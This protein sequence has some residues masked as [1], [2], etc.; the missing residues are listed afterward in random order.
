MRDRIAQWYTDTRKDLFIGACIAFIVFITVGLFRL[1]APHVGKAPIIIEALPH[2]ATVQRAG[3]REGSA[4]AERLGAFV[5][6]RNGKKYY[7]PDCP[8]ANRIKP[9]NR[10]WFASVREA[11]ETGYEPAANCPA[12]QP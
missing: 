1:A 2:A 12:L 11:Q 8:A 4:S 10:I 9:E 3:E 6:S 7:P 5:A